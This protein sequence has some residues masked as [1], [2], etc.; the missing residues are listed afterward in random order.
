MAVPWAPE[1]P[2][3]SWCSFLIKKYYFLSSLRVCTHCFRTAKDFSCP[4]SYSKLSKSTTT[5]VKGRSRSG[6]RPAVA[7]AKVTSETETDELP[8]GQEVGWIY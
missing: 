4:Y 7:E 8:E 3:D 1:C 2:R 6:R 5:G